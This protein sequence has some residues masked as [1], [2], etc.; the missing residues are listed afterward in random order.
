MKRSNRSPNLFAKSP[1]KACIYNIKV[2]NS[3]SLFV[4]TKSFLKSAQTAHRPAK[5][6]NSKFCSINIYIIRNVFQFGFKHINQP[7]IFNKKICR[8]YKVENSL[9]YSRQ[10]P[11]TNPLIE[12]IRNFNF[13]G[14]EKIALVNTKLTIL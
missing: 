4:K 12:S 1:A 8:L 13:T 7:K 6:F 14:T 9:Q 10:L 3:E 2:E 5:K 11:R